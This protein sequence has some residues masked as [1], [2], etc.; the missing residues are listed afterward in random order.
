MR[1]EMLSGKWRE[2]GVTGTQIR[3]VLLASPQASPAVGDAS[4][5]TIPSWTLNNDE[6]C[7]V[8]TRAGKKRGRAKWRGKRWSNP[9]CDN[10]ISSQRFQ[11]TPGSTVMRSAP[12]NLY[13]VCDLP[14][15]LS[16]ILWSSNQENCAPVAAR[17]V[18]RRRTR[19]LVLHQTALRSNCLEVMLWLCG[20]GSPSSRRP[21]S[22][23]FLRATR[24]HSRGH[25]GVAGE[26]VIL[27]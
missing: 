13:S 14:P 15:K 23:L 19:E 4:D 18:V 26:G 21:T 11:L 12:Y 6:R 24:T 2:G 8:A 5:I 20:P 9:I 27:G 22:T 7:P 10:S 25:G 1:C 16:K 3:A 17:L